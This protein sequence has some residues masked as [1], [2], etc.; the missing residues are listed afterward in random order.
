MDGN[1]QVAISY[2]F[3]HHL[4]RVG[5]GEEFVAD[6][7]GK[8]LA[9]L[10]QYPDIIGDMVFALGHTHVSHIDSKSVVPALTR[11]SRAL[12]KLRSSHIAQKDIEPKLLLALGLGALE[13]SS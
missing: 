8:V 9:L 4:R 7:N 3:Q 6:G 12:A 2:Y 11:K 10:Q 1:D 5:L 13:V